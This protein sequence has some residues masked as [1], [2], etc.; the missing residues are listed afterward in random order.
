VLRGAH[1]ALQGWRLHSL[2]VGTIVWQ[3]INEA[4]PAGSYFPVVDDGWYVMLALMSP[5]HHY[6]HFTASGGSQNITNDLIVM[7]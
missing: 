6:I 5:G 2:G 1:V 4:I 7:H 3:A